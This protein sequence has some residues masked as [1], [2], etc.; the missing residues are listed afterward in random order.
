MRSPSHVKFPSSLTRLLFLTGGVLACAPLTAQTSAALHSPA[1]AAAPATIPALFLSDIHFDPFLDP[2]KAVAL[3]AAPEVSWPHIL[4]GGHSTALTAAQQSAFEACSNQ[5]DTSYALWQS[6]LTELRKTAGSSR[7]VVLSG[8]LLGHQFDCK[9]KALVD[10]ATAA[11]YLDFTLKTARYVLTTLHA[12]LPGVPIYTALGNNDSGCEDYALDAHDDAFLAAVA[13]LIA[14]AANVAPADR[15]SVERDFAVL[16]AYN[17][18]LA[19]MPHTRI[20]SMDDLYL[21]A[22]YSTCAGAHDAVPAANAI[23][24]LKTQLDLARA[25][26]E[27]V[28]FVGHI[29]PGVDLYATARRMAN[30]C[31]GAKPT[32]FLGSEDLAQ[33]LAANSDVVRLALFGHTHDDEVRLLTPDDGQAQTAN[34][35]GAA[36]R[37]I[38]ESAEPAPVA[39]TGVPLKIV[40]S[41]TPVH[42]NRPSFML[43]RVDPATATLIDYTVMMASNPMVTPITWSR[44]YTYSATYHKPAFDA[45]SLTAL[46]ADFQGDP[47]DKWPASQAY[48]RNYF[49]AEPAAAAANSAVI[50]AAWQPYACSLNHDSP[51]SFAACTCGK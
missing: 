2:T 28:W 33:S 36:E 12:A 27:R 6:T 11:S 26:H 32:M 34:A 18:P 39:I 38:P 37:T 23:A 19:A 20:V 7:F 51:K 44:E 22:K 3:N 47:S 29:P 35:G 16:G 42:G 25:A 50:S 5:T 8:D 30:V 41:I 40:A 31:G 14:Q 21:S 13:P 46:I 15:T 1:R 24:W 48:I 45:A 10:G 49:P 9:Y 17:A 4:A 43:A